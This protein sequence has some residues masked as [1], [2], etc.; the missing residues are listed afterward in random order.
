MRMNIE[1]TYKP[2]KQFRNKVELELNLSYSR[3]E[4]NCS[5]LELD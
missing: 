3:T 2:Y 1:L 5:N 4:L